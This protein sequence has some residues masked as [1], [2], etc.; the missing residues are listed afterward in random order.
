VVSGAGLGLDANTDRQVAADGGYVHV[1]YRDTAG[2]IQYT[3]SADNGVTWQQPAGWTGLGASKAGQSPGIAAA[4]GTVFISFTRAGGSSGSVQVWRATGNGA[5]WDAAPTQMRGNSNVTDL[6]WS[7]VVAVNDA[8]TIRANVFWRETSNGIRSRATA[9]GGTSWNAVVT[10]LPSASAGVG[11]GRASAAAP[12]GL[13]LLWKPSAAAGSITVSTN[14]GAAW[15]AATALPTTSAYQSVYATAAAGSVTAFRVYSDAVG[16]WVQ[17]YAAGAWGT[18]GKVSD[19]ADDGKAAASVAIT[20]SGSRLVTAWSYAAAATTQMTSRQSTDGAITWGLV[21]R[22]PVVAG[23]YNLDS[24]GAPADDHVVY[25]AITAPAAIYHVGWTVDTTPPN[26]PTGLASSAVTSSSAVLAW[27]VPTDPPPGS[28]VV[29]Y[30]IYRDGAKVGT[31]SVA[32]F[33]ATGLVVSTAYSFQVTAVDGDGNVSARSAALGVTTTAAAFSM[34]ML[35][36]GTVDFGVVNVGATYTGAVKPQIQVQSDEPWDYS[37][38]ATSLTAGSATF[39]FSEFV[40]DNGTVA[41]GV[42]KPAGLTIDTRTVTLDLTS[43]AAWT[44]PANTPMNATVMY[45]AVQQP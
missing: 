12:Q 5:T 45:T 26:V 30:E 42:G 29:S 33:S 4:N 34:T 44:I 17:R 8:G 35:T 20:G 19:P 7:D 41:F 23:A 18:A 13:A 9:N 14:Q 24:A 37:A 2:N 15:S 22:L 10:A 3:R 43:D 21:K 25:S 40:R 16:V 1:V 28:G 11:F 36:T 38:T 27:N 39:P 31:S 32:S 6:T